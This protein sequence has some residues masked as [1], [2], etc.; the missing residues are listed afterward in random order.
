MPEL[1][2]QLLG[3][4]RIERDG[5][6]LAVDTR[7][8]TA[9][10]AYL[11][12][13]GEA[14]S[15]DTLAALFWP[16]V[17]EARAALRRTLSALNK[18]LNGQ[19]LEIDRETI[20]LPR[21]PGWWLDVTAFHERL[22]DCRRRG[23]LRPGSGHSPEC[24]PP[25]TE[26]A[27]LYRDDFLAGFT[28]R[29]SPGFD[30]W[31]FFQA[32]TLR[33]E[34]A[35][36]LETLAH[37]HREAGQFEAAIASARRWLTLDPMHEPAHRMLMQLYA[38][39]GQ[40][41]LA[42]RQYRECVRVLEADLGVAPLEE[43]TTLYESIKQ[44]SKHAGG[45]GSTG[46]G[47]QFDAGRISP[48]P[49]PPSEAGSPATASPAPLHPGSPAS[50]LPLVNR[51]AELATLARAMESLGPDGF[52]VGLEGEAGIG[53][54]RLAEEF[55]HRA[56]EIW[57]KPDAAIFAARC[58]EGEGRMALGPFVEGLR[59]LLPELSPA[60]AAGE[61]ATPR[62][63]EWLASLP[64]HWQGEIARLL[65]EVSGALAGIPPAP[66]ESGL[67]PQRASAGLARGNRARRSSA[68]DSPGAQGRLFEGVR[69]FLLAAR[70]RILFLDDLQCADEASLDLLTYLVRR[71][72]GHAL[73]VLATWRSEQV[74]SSHR[75][76]RLL[77]DVQRAG[78]GAHLSLSRLSVSAV[79]ELIR[80][81]LPSAPAGESAA[82]MEQLYRETEGL[83]FFVVE[84][85]A[86][87]RRGVGRAVWDLPEGAR[88]LLHSRLESVSETGR[89]L[90]SAAA[91]IGRS[92]DFDVL[93]YASGR[94]E[95]ETVAALETLMQQGMVEEA[96]P[97]GG[98]A[99][100]A[101]TYDFSHEKLRAFVYEQTSLA[102]RRLLHR[103]VA[104]A[105]NQPG[106]GRRGI[107]AGELARH[108]RLGGMEAEAAHYFRLAGEQA[109][110]L[111][112]NAQALAH[113][114]AAL[115]L[116]H[117]D[118]AALHEAIGDLLTLSGEYGAALAS[119][120]SAAA[121]LEPESAALAS[122]E[123]RIG[124]LYHRQ[125]EWDLAAAQFQAALNA[126]G[127]V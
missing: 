62:L 100:G 43:T 87:L 13:T 123:H 126:R 23:Y 85:L 117:P 38:R 58:F 28:L 93:R 19:W 5:R 72:R 127:A 68:L 113:F 50:S 83:P 36:A 116:G 39:S 42:L 48:A 52:C 54:T 34:M 69:Q 3:P 8:A 104:E 1:K 77:A 74:E 110:A 75:L 97:R 120:E 76:R 30:D 118:P 94:S 112:A 99:G 119:Y 114:R 89:Q 32:E 33:R 15:R 21:A 101:L 22:A 14:H 35:G 40:R 55:L 53:K 45:R 49:P 103:R 57:L 59:G 105:L 65:P 10:L 17:D 2:I 73:L 79:A 4:P 37:C 44:G 96:G 78:Q 41:A 31:Q 60:R 26:A 24:V 71:L 11:A 125:G 107:P 7:K 51:E 95:E 12:V 9:L 82:L 86:T 84:Y 111:Y 88:G 25:L 121:L 90:L 18:A 109:R 108:F 66:P 81:A 98:D 124:N 16:D 47:E 67:S 106:R 92:F 63:P 91:V 56:R 102:R 80:S 64:P 122:V 46:A 70:I 115:A 27:A 29:D 61:A 6:P 20:H